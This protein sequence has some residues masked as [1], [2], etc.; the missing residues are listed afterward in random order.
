MKVC[1]GL[2]LVPFSIISA[3]TNTTTSLSLG[4]LLNFDDLHGKCLQLPLHT[5]QYYTQGC[6]V[7]DQKDLRSILPS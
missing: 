3:V 1:H 5:P 2:L 4:P 6:K 7:L